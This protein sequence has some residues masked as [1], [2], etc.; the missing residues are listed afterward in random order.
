MLDN[1]QFPSPYFWIFEN[2][3]T[4]LETWTTGELPTLVAGT[5]EVIISPFGF[6]QLAFSSAAQMALC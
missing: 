5:E 6:G 4:G 2:P 1:A 3:A